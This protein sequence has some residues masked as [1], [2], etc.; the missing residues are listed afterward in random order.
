MFRNKKITVLG[1]GLLGRG[2]GDVEFLAECGARVLVTDK[3]SK[4]ELAESIERL[5]KYKNISFRLGGHKTED[6]T[7]CDFVV[8]AAGVPLDSPEIATARHSGV[9]VYMSTAL[10]AK[11][12][13]ESGA[14]IVGV[15]GT[16]GKSTVAHMIYHTLQKAKKH[17]NI[18]KN[19]RMFLGGNVRGKSTLALLPE[20]RRADVV[21]LELD[22]WQLQGF[23]DLKISPH[24]AVFTNFL[25]DHVNYYPTTDAYF[26][27]K[28]NIFKF[29][30]QSDVLIVG[31]LVAKKVEAAR[32]KAAPQIA[33]PIPVEWKLKVIGEHNR[34][35]A[36]LAVAAL[37]SLGIAEKDIRAGLES[38]EGVEGRLQFVREVNGVKIYNDN[39][40][41]TPEA[42]IAAIRSVKELG[43]LTIIVGGTEKSIELSGLAKE[44]N[45]LEGGVVLFSGTGTEKLKPLLTSTFTEV[46]TLKD[47]LNVAL[48]TAPKNGTVLFSPAF[49][50]FGPF[51]NYYD[52]NDQFLALVK[53]L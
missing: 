47:A 52:R 16:R 44:L 9:P 15:T 22:S 40:A 39:H 33:M 49:A 5:K 3:K 45:E 38:F 2:V 42:T 25:Q 17:S 8:K 53:A 4:S 19:I 21:V 1:L 51:V 32:T 50:S 7:A 35:N 27:D 31:G 20:V 43:P 14:K 12:A 10:F 6:F 29:Q 18:L 13:T 24:I 36:S 37:E 41:S 46:G 34:E 30:K 48:K 23:G 11:F 28:A 26:A